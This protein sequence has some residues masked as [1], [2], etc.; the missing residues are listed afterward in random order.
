MNKKYVLCLCIEQLDHEAVILVL[1][2]KPI[3][4]SCRKCCTQQLPQQ[5]NLEFEVQ[6]DRG[7]SGE[8]S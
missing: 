1:I 6:S 7:D 4:R 8:M 5:L 2:F 3:L